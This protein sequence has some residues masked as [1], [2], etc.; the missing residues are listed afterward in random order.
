MSRPA[1]DRSCRKRYK[2]API[3]RQV[4]AS[5]M[6]ITTKSQHHPN[7]T[8]L[9]NPLIL[10]KMRFIQATAIAFGLLD[11]AIAHSDWPPFNSCICP[12]KMWCHGDTPQCTPDNTN[13]TLTH[14]CASGQI[15]LYGKCVSRGSQAC[16]DGETICSGPESQCAVDNNGKSICCASGQIAING[17]CVSRGSNLCSDN[18]TICSGT[19]SQ[20]SIDTSGKSICCARGQVAVSGKC[21]EPGSNACSDGKT[22]CS[23]KNSQCTVDVTVFVGKDGG[24]VADTVCCEPGQK[25]INGKCYDGKAKIMPCYRGPC[26]WSQNVYCAWNVGNGD[27]RCCKMNEYYAGNSCVRKR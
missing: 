5:Y 26:D 12:G 21:A 15:A 25:A 13:A 23:G 8:S 7:F 18:E 17:N 6:S 10:A 1:R 14:C 3:T 22:V 11:L 4:E 20:C 27:S 9:Y 19:E 16:P 24:A 2:R